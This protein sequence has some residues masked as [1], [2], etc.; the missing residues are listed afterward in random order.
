[1]SKTL[2]YKFFRLGRVPRRVRGQ[3]EREGIVLQDEGLRGTV[4][5]KDYKAPGRY[6][7]W[8]RTWFSGSIVLTQEHLLVF[9]YARPIIGVPWQDERLEALTIALE[10][11]NRIL[12]S[13]D[14]ASF[15]EGVSGEVAIRLSTPLAE[16]I[17]EQIEVLQR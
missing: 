4:T 9:E 15:H 11:G 10:E 7:S 5:L 3:I 6:H 17:L 1:M 13:F 12:I 16:A 2:L 14:A 8:R